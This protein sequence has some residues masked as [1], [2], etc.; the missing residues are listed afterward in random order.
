[1]GRGDRRDGAGGE[2][3]ESG[4]QPEKREA[5]G[6]RQ[7]ELELARGRGRGRVSV[8]VLL[9]P[10]LPP[11]SFS[12]LLVVVLVSLFSLSPYFCSL[13]AYSNKRDSI[14]IGEGDRC[15]LLLRSGAR[16]PFRP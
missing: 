5:R 1:M 15:A 10:F 7:E 14:M 11:F 3:G 16:S 8:F 9:S 6:N 13:P 4:S 12:F 2:E